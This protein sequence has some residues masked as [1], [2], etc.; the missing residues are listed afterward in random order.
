MTGRW[1]LESQLA[2]IIE[3]R[4]RRDWEQFHYPKDL[5]AG[6]SIEAAELQELFL[7]KGQESAEEVRTDA[8][9]MEE[10]TDEVADVAIYLILMA[11][12]LDIDLPRAIDHKLRK[13]AVKNPAP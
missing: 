5:A 2:A 7:W 8:P 1:D 12:T 13:N 11:H 9:R 3:F 10:I 6:I 4:D